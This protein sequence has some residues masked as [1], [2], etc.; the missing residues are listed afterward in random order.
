MRCVVKN[1][2]KYWIILKLIYYHFISL[3]ARLENFEQK[4]HFE[5]EYIFD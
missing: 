5:D 1:K 3:D 4:D 2:V